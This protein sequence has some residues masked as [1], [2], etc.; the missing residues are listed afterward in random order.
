[1]KNEDSS[2]WDQKLKEVMKI[3]LD[4]EKLQNEL[5]KETTVKQLQKLVEQRRKKRARRKQLHKKE[6]LAKQK[7]LSS[8]DELHAKIDKDMQKIVE[9]QRAKKQEED[10]DKEADMILGQVR[11]KL[12]ETGRYQQLLD[13]LSKLRRLRTDRLERQGVLSSIYAGTGSIGAR[14]QVF[15]NKISSLKELLDKQMNIYKAEESTLKVLLEKEQKETKEKE[16]AQTRQ[17]RAEALEREH[18]IQHRKLFGKP[19]VAQPGD[20]IYSFQ[21]FYESASHSLDN[22]VSVRMGWDMHLTLPDT[23]GASCIPDHW[24]VPEDPSSHAWAS[25]LVTKSTTP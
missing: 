3:K 11:K 25:Y 21:Q 19:K 18:T 5:T 9:Q 23:P 17:R 10:M 15:E 16:D 1:M 20:P 13:S 4:V 2:I 12:S 8:R 14:N 6:Y 7:E 22:L 24:V